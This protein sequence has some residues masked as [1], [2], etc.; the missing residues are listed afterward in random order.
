MPNVVGDQKAGRLG[1]VA[2]TAYRHLVGPLCIGD[3]GSDYNGWTWAERTAATP[4]QKRALAEGAIRQPTV[5]GITGFSAP[6]DPRGRGYVFMHNEDYGRPLEF[7][8][9][10]RRRITPC[11]HASPIHCGG[12]AWSGVITSMVHG[13]H[14]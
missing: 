2:R 1:G 8:A 9:V 14:S 11:T 6:D 10:S 3:P 4:V 12:F 7:Y 5:C 13:S